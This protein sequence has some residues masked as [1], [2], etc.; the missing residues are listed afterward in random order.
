MVGLVVQ[1]KR[2][3][4]GVINMTLIL[5]AIPW[6]IVVWLIPGFLIARFVAQRDGDE[7]GGTLLLIIISGWISAFLFFLAW[8]KNRLPKES[9][10]RA[11]IQRTVNWLS[12]TEDRLF[13][14][15]T[16]NQTGY[17]SEDWMIRG[18]VDE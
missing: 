7:S 9:H 1:V 4:L 6:F 11:V 5:I 10:Y 16:E 15:S 13:H 18:K 14:R 12:D 8:L 17:T 2:S 3:N